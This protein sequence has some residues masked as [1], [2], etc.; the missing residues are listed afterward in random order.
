[1][2]AFGRLTRLKPGNV[3]ERKVMRAITILVVLASVAIPAT[4]VADQSHK[5]KSAKG[6]LVFLIDEDS[7]EW[8]GKLLS[9]SDDALT[10]EDS[11][12]VREFPLTKVKRIDAEG[13]GIRDGA[14]KGA[15][16]G[17]VVGVFYAVAF[18]DA[19]PILG[20]AL[21]YGLIGAGIDA[22]N[23]SKQTVYRGPAKLAVTVRW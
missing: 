15:I 19:R 14:I 21:T 3:S 20:G 22:I 8:V 9:V 5:L 11:N 13:D 23:R 4:A 7:R 18:D 12:G 16:F 10:I 17:A 2:P 6:E 1:M